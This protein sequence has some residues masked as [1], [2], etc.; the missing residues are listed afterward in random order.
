M[1]ET[2]DFVIGAEVA[3]TDRVCGDLKRVVVDPVARELTHL[4]VQPMRAAGLGKLVPTSLVESATDRVITLRCTGAEFEAL[5]DAQETDFV[6]GARGKW[7]YGQE[8]MLSF[9]YFGTG[10]ATM[11]L[12]HLGAGML[13]MGIDSPGMTT[14][15]QSITR[16]R[17]PLGEVEIRRGNRVHAT[18][19]AIG[20]VRGLVVDPADRHVTHV[21]LEEGHLWGKKN[22]AI[23][24]GSVAS[25]GDEIRLTLTKDQVKD[26]PAVEIDAD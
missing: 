20:D 19:G 10:L 5:E 23:P 14:E 25:V 7:G 8:Q 12:G 15:P 13:S 1:T 21:L 18:D 17:V 11:P 4:V 9:P 2:T 6:P 24:I 16:D 3:C 26:L 22:V